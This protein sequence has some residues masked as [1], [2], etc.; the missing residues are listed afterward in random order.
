MIKIIT[1]PEPDMVYLSNVSE[2]LPV[3]AKRYGKLA[4]MVVEEE[5]GWILR[6]GGRAHSNGFHASRGKCIKSCLEY[7]YDFFIED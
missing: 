7:G 3:F 5:E 1:D 4:G 2:E 6:I